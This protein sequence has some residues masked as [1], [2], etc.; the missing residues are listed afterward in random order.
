M[1]QL[2]QETSPY[3]LQHRDNPVDW[4]PWSPETFDEAK[5]A[6]KPILLSVGYAAC[7]WCHVMAH[8]SFEDEET[9]A[10]MN[11]LYVNIKVDREERPDVDALYQHALALLG[12]HGGWPLTMFLTPQGA[13]F[14]GGT[15]FPPQPSYGRPSFKD[16]LTGIAKIWADSQDKVET[17][18]AALTDGLSTWAQSLPGGPVTPELLDQVA[19]RLAT[20]LDPVEGGM[21]GAPKFPNMPIMELFR[22]AWWRSGRRAHWESYCLA[23]TRMSQGGIYDHVGGGY[24]RYTVDDIW[25]V[26]HFEKMLYDNAQIL[27]ALA[28]AYA[29]EGDALYRHRAEETVRWLLREMRAG[30]KAPGV[31]DR[32]RPQEPFV[33]AFAASFDADSEGHEGL[34]YL[35]TP[36]QVAAVLPPETAQAVNASYDITEAGNF[37]GRA[38]PNRRGAPYGE[39]ALPEADLSA[40]LEDLY[41][42]RAER[43]WPGWDDKVLA[44]WNGLTI[45]SLAEAGRIFA[46]PD[47]CAAAQTALDF[48]AADMMPEGRLHHSWRHGTVK[49]LAMID[50]L[51]QIARA[52]LLLF[53]A[54]GES[55]NLKLAQDL[56]AVAEAR[57]W[58]GAG[59]GY[60]TAP[61]DGEQLIVRAKAVNDNAQP[62]ANGTMVEV[63]TRLYLLT[64][65]EHYRARAQAC[66]AAFTGGFQRNVYPYA[67]LLNAAEFLERAVQVV[68]VGERGEAKAEALADAAWQAGNPWRV[69]QLVESEAALPEGHPAKGK[70]VQ[71]GAPT[72]YV[73]RGPLCSLPIADAAELR[74]ALL[75]RSA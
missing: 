26:P 23:L 63:L 41:R 5:R 18:V 21:S 37:E 45:A 66:V 2:A 29:V 14:W 28:A 69:L 38:I 49:H 25:L 62:S 68:I 12:E 44:D 9:A 73:C 70:V 58:D 59:G 75:E 3:L 71:D 61:D 34:F 65:R 24:A 40:A 35:W 74:E 54:N 56:E 6:G 32:G 1:N 39:A 20:A 51:A 60:F 57:H 55:R 46:K 13:P 33:P 50:D 17:N 47:W 30:A 53:E 7:H 43:I 64:G 19:D 16:V 52:A 31:D 10:L 8:E 4:R 36:D 72:A 22:R 48:V 15:Y 27:S 67:T 11:D 42:I